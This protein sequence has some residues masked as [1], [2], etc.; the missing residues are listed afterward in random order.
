MRILVTGKGGKSGSWAIRAEQLGAAIGATVAARADSREIEAADL[1]VVVKRTPTDLIDRI[2]AAGKRWVFDV[3]DGWPQPDGNAWSEDRAVKWL[4][5]RLADL[6]PDAVVFPTGMMREDAA[7]AVPAIVLPH[8]AWPKYAP[9]VLHAKVRR[10]GY[11]GGERYLGKWRAII[12][13]QCKRRGWEFVINGDLAS[14]QIGI[15]LRDVPGYPAPAWKANTK[16]ANL[17]ALGIPALCSP[18]R[19]YIETRSGGERWAENRQDVERC[20]DAWT[21]SGDRKLA[22][23]AMLRAVPT[24]QQ[25]AERYRTWLHQ[26]SF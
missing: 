19:G 6:R 4:R 20:F 12:E 18:E 5:H 22:R 13:D 17:Q 9:D 14:C 16:L 10:V 8:H 7:F 23:D 1:I 26:L 24:L 25:I 15:A 21:Y 2:R 11:E 3:V